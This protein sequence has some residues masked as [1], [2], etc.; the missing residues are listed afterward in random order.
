MDS[1]VSTV[2]SFA[3]SRDHYEKEVEYG[4]KNNMDLETY[5]LAKEAMVSGASKEEF[6]KFLLKKKSEKKGISNKRGE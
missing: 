2:F 4:A 5:K 1:T 6:R 3:Y